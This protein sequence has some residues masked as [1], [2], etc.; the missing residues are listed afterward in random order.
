MKLQLS[1]FATA[2]GINIII[3]ILSTVSSNYAS[4][5]INPGVFPPDSKPYG[6]TYGVILIKLA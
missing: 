5:N 6:L 1:I 3:L 4:D 2:S